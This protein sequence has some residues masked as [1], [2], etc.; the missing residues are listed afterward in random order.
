SSLEEATHEYFEGCTD[1][2]YMIVTFDVLPDKRS[3][4]PAVTHTDNTARVQT[5]NRDT[6]PRYWKLIESF[7]KL[8]GVPVIMNTSFNLRGEPIVCTP[9]D[10][11][12]TFYSSGLDFLIMGNFVIAKDQSWQPG[13]H[14]S[15]GSVRVT[16]PVHPGPAAA[17][18]RS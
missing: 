5:V 2:P 17:T 1:A 4:I 16:A 14:R 15:E 10:A 13:A 7:A 6:N 9:K 18:E 11:V 8:T 3:V 12:R